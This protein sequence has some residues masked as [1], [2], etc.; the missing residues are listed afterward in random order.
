MPRDQP[1]AQA[2]HGRV[3]A[4]GHRGGGRE[5]DQGE[6]PEDVHRRCKTRVVRKISQVL[7]TRREISP[8]VMGD[9]TQQK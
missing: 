6:S 3:Q 5:G 9:C 2:L 7:A 8:K 1:Q 4:V